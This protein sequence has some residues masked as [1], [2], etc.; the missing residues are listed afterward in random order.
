LQP[1]AARRILM[2]GPLIWDEAMSMHMKSARGSLIAPWNRGIAAFCLFAVIAFPAMAQSGGTLMPPGPGGAQPSQ[3]SQQQDITAAPQPKLPKDYP[4]W[5]GYLVV[6][7]MVA[8]I[9]GASLMPSKRS[10]Q[11]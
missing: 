5:V 1:A 10:H 9:M 8:V 11:D 6:F 4:V 2:A 7:L 3:P